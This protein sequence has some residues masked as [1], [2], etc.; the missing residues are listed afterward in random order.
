[1]SLLDYMAKSCYYAQDNYCCP[2]SWEEYVTSDSRYPFFEGT[3]YQIACFLAQN[4]K[5]GDGGVGGD[6]IL[7]DL[8]DPSLNDKGLMLKS[9][10]E[11]KVI[12]QNLV[13]DLGGF[14]EE[15]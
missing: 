4:T 2:I 3:S 5:K 1:M 9:I 14:K 11:W 12:L 13:D 15:K 10:E 6:V 8:S 7:E